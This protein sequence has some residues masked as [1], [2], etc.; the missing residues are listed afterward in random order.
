MRALLHS[1]PGSVTHWP[2][3]LGP[4]Q[5]LGAGQVRPQH[6]TQEHARPALG[7]RSRDEAWQKVKCVRLKGIRHQCFNAVRPLTMGAHTRST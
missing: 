2:T 7:L 1:T 6:L 3:H 4:R 5:H